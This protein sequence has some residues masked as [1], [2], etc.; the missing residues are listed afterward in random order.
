MLP[1][2]TP[3]S[4]RRWQILDTRGSSRP[5]CYATL[6]SL[7]FSDVTGAELL[8]YLLHGGTRRSVR[9]EQIKF[10]CYILLFPPIR[11]KREFSLTRDHNNP[12]VTDLFPPLHSQTR[13]VLNLN[14]ISSQESN[15]VNPS[16]VLQ[17]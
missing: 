15:F 16:I 9:Y 6:V 8:L 1:I 14:C 13:V 11:R 3:K 5:T 12:H 17:K 4:P 7:L 10:T 2:K